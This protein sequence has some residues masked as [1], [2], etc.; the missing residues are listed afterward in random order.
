M[1]VNGTVTLNSSEMDMLTFLEKVQSEMLLGDAMKAYCKMAKE[2][3]RAAYGT[4][5]ILSRLGFIGI[6]Y[7]GH[8]WKNPAFSVLDPNEPVEKVYVR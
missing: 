7:G 2:S 1:G 3:R 5:A 8:E 6:D 4:L